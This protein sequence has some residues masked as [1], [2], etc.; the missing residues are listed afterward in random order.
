MGKG[1]GEKAWEYASLRRK[2]VKA[3]RRKGSLKPGFAVLPLSR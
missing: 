3:Q 2:G 1:A